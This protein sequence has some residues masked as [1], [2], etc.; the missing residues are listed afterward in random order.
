MAEF[1]SKNTVLN[2]N[3]QNVYS[4][5]SDFRNFSSLIP[6]DKA[7]DFEAT[8]DT[9]SFVAGGMGKISL[10]YSKKTLE[11]IEIV[12]D[13]KIP[14]EGEIKLFVNLTDKQEKC[15]AI[16]GF[17]AN[18]PAMYKMMLKRPLQN[19]VDMIAQALAKK[20]E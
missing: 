18:I 3:I 20:Y 8:E 15:E 1:E 17:E 4:F 13:M 10:K 19:L 6:A 14:V 7:S 16:V 5:L 2:E 11:K 9:C 12:P